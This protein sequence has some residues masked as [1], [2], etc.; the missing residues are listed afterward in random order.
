MTARPASKRS[1]PPRGREDAVRLA[2]LALL[3]AGFFVL[4]DPRGAFPLNDDFS[5]AESARGLLSGAGLRIP[6]WV[7]SSTVSHTAL[8]ALMTAPWGASNQ[9]LRLWMILLGGLGVCGVYALARR[10]KAG[11]DAALLAAATLAFSPLYAA[12]SASFHLDVTASVFTLAALLCFLRGRQEGSTRWLALC[13][14]LIAASGL[15]RQTGFL[16]ALGGAASLAWERRLTARA[17]AALLLPAG[18]A[19]LVFWAWVRFVHGPT[20]AWE[21]AMSTPT[22]SIWA[23]SATWVRTLDRLSR[24]LQTGALFL[25]P[26]AVLSMRDGALRR[27]SRKEASLLAA[28]AAGA[29]WGLSRGEGLPLLQ[30]TLSRTGLGVVLL[31][32]AQ[33]K[34]AGWWASPWLWQG[35]G[36]LA[37]ACSL[38]LTRRLALT[39]DEEVSR[40]RGAA[41]LF[42]A[43]AFLPALLMP[44]MYDRYLL[45]L[46]PVAAAATAAG[47]SIKTR[48]L[49]PSLLGLGLLVFCSGAGL[50]DYFS[51]NRARWAAGM[52]AVELGVPPE[53]VE[54]GFDWDGQFSLAR[55]L[56]ALRAVKPAKEIGVWEWQELNRI[57]VRTSFSAPEKM[58][59][60]TLV[61]RFPYA[62]PLVPDGGEVRLYAHPALF[63]AARR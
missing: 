37:L 47:Q 2:G 40:E 3:W 36:I 23:D 41:A 16:C 39:E 1:R 6:E 9:A 38:A 22:L 61:G 12:M 20:W 45:I 57:L 63:K 21:S 29:L 14:L 25:A 35:A 7:L 44:T 5:Y 48:A 26:L 30:N 42:V 50:R 4:V 24:S 56:A 15:T 54:N 62:T 51:W 43:A 49:V 52:S 58:P 60:W 53:R 10:W 11:P 55:N 19:A 27:P 8:G 32:G 59:G 17:A 13:S 33:D 28:I 46:L 34:P 31:D 18:A